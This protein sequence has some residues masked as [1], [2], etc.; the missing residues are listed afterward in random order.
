[1]KYPLELYAG[2]VGLTKVHYQEIY[3][4]MYTACGTNLILFCAYTN[5]IT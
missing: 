3:G 4:Q 2:A 5:I 1:M